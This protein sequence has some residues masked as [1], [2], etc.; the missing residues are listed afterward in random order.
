LNI[1][2]SPVNHFVRKG[3]TTLNGATP[4]LTTFV[5]TALIIMTH[6][7]AT[8]LVN[9]NQSKNKRGNVMLTAECPNQPI[10]LSIVILSIVMLHTVMMGPL[11]FAT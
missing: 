2:M 9:Y 5:I 7:I 3:A 6:S 10:I 4:S 8:L 11:Y 1:L